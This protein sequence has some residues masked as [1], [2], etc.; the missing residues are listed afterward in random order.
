MSDRWFAVTMDTWGEV[1]E[2]GD[3]AIDGLIDGLTAVGAV[4]AAV[5]AGGTAGGVSATVSVEATDADVAAAAALHQFRDA[6]SKASIELGPVARVDVMDETYQERWLDEPPVELVGVSEIAELLDVSRQRIRE[7][8]QQPGFPAPL[9]ELKAGPV[10]SRGSLDRF[11]RSWPRK[12][13]RPRDLRAIDREDFE[14][15]RSTARWLKHSRG[16]NAELGPDVHTI[17]I[18][19]KESSYELWDDR[20]LL[21]ARLEQL[22]GDGLVVAQEHAVPPH[23]PP[24]MR[25]RLTPEAWRLLDEVASL[26]T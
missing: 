26:A 11:H 16:L 1:A 22:I 6:A 21:A 9:A 3:E 15:L 12:P 25:Y 23:M 10:W 14:I 2:M 17:A 8:R 4:G 24:E 19:L 7:L 18:P 13:G 20:E 5:A